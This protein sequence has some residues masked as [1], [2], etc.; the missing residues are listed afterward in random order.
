MRPARIIWG[1]LQF[2]KSNSCQGRFDVLYEE[3]LKSIKE[4]LEIILKSKKFNKM[5]SCPWHSKNDERTINDYMQSW[6]RGFRLR[7]PMPGFHPGIYAESNVI[8][9]RDPFAHFIREGSPRGPWLLPVVTPKTVPV[10]E[11]ATKFNAALHIHFYYPDQADDVLRLLNANTY[12]PDLFISVKS[13]ED[14]KALEKKLR[15]VRAKKIVIRKVPNQGRNFGPLFTEFREIFSEY[16]IFGHLHTKQSPHIH[17]RQEAQVWN[18]FLWCNLIGDQNPMMDRIIAEL[19]GN[20][21]LGLV[22]PD[23]PNVYGWFNNAPE[24]HILASRMGIGT[25]HPSNFINFP[26]GG[27]FWGRSSAFKPLLDLNLSWD[28]YPV[29]PIGDDGTMLHALERMIP[30]IVQ[31]AGFSVA[32]THVEGTTR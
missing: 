2:S 15:C 13:D 14:R 10:S 30:N 18:N 6:K 25:F 21:T 17:D 12:T 19:S 5:F 32:V 28:D 7:K 1:L 9:N 31:H 8:K 23:D 11:A 29:E 3:R 4:D 27:M 26:A 22:Y 16:D 20:A 24:A